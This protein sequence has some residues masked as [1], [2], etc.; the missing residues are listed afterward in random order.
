MPAMAA[1]GPQFV[2]DAEA[3]LLDRVLAGERECFYE[4]IRPYERAIFMTAMSICRNE[5]D[6]EEIAQ[7]AMLRAL[8]ALPSFRRESKFSTWLIQITI[9]EAR[10]RVRKDRKHLYEST[11]EPEPAAAAEGDYRPKDY[12][13]WREIPSE[14]L[15]RKELRTA[16]QRALESLSPLY[17]EVFIMRDVQKLSIA[18]TAAALGLKEATVKIRLLRARLQ[19]RDA[20]APG[21]DGAWALGENSYRKVRPWGPAPA[22]WRKPK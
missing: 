7:E 17:R 11:D 9:N 5:A 15:E 16:L 14:A 6:A 18:E 3:A 12:A 1:S 21:V 20:L 13:D 22:N 4:L 8:T 10:M 2:T 19:M